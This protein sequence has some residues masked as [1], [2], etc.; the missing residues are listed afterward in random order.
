[1]KISILP[2]TRL[3]TW[4]VLLVLLMPL[5]FKLG[6]LVSKNHYINTP[7]GN[8]IAEDVFS[9]PGVALPML[10]GF[11]SGIAAFVLGIVSITT[12]GERSLLTCISMII[13]MLLILFL[14]A[15]IISP[16]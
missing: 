2:K 5:L 14:L 8:T 13:G 11:F 12:K 10:T 6:F 7:A 4:P 3:G 1:M 16:H 15:E 9:R